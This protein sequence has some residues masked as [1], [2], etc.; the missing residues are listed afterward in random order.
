MGQIGYS[1]KKL[2]HR[3]GSD[4]LT[5]AIKLFLYTGALVWVLLNL[6]RCVCVFPDFYAQFHVLCLIFASFNILG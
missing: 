6:R 1:T 5:S 3:T 4:I 2:F